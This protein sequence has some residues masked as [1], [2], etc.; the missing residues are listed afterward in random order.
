MKEKENAIVK[1]KIKTGGVQAG[2]IET[3]TRININIKS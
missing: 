1:R 3:A 2:Q